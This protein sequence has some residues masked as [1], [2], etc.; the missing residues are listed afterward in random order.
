MWRECDFHRAISELKA[1]L[2][3]HSISKRW[4]FVPISETHKS[5]LQACFTVH[6][7]N[8]LDLL[9]KPLYFKFISTSYHWLYGKFKGLINF[10]IMSSAMSK[11]KSTSEL[12][13][14]GNKL[15]ALGGV[16]EAAMR[17]SLVLSVGLLGYGTDQ[18][19]ASSLK[20]AGADLDGEGGFVEDEDDLFR[21]DDEWVFSPFPFFLCIGSF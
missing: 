10:I 7:P 19:D 15:D 16:N 5:K 9:L 20:A 14:K 21:E 12:N 13:A 4:S 2:F 17:R 11:T 3:Q 6:N 8:P 18:N 1:V